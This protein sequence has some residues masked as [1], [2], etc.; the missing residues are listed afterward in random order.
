MRAVLQR[1]SSASVS[2][3]S[4]RVG[5]I[6]PGLVVLVGVEELDGADDVDWLAGRIAALRLFR[7]G[8]AAWARSVTELGGDIL[9]VSQFTLHASTKKGTK[10]SWHRAAKPEAAVRLYEAL[11]C[12]LETLLAKPL[13]TG[14]F[15][16]MMKVALVNDG[17]VTL[18]LD[19]KN[20]E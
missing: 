19:S 4:E 3:D 5:E 2:I 7:D 17:P 1:V 16:A 12:R 9:L 6:G 10:P 14:R 18:I 13:A 20:R 8:A 15:G 11:R